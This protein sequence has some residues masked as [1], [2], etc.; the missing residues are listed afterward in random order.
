MTLLKKTI[1]ILLL[2]NFLCACTGVASLDW[3]NDIIGGTDQNFTNQVRIQH[4]TKA[5]KTSQFVKDLYEEIPAFETAQDPHEMTRVVQ[6]LENNMYTPQDLSKTE[7][8]PNDVPY[9]GTTEFK[10]KRMNE[11]PQKRISTEVAL[12]ISGKASG[13]EALQKFVHNDLDMGDPPM[14]WDNQLKTEPTFNLNHTREWENERDCVLGMDLVS[15]S[16]TKYRVGTINT[17]LEFGHGYK[18]GYNVDNLEGNN[19]DLSF[20]FAVFGSLRGVVRNF[21]YDGN[22]FQ[23]SQYHVTSSPFVAAINFA[24]TLNWRNY[25][26]QFNYNIRSKDY[27]EQNNPT[28]TFGVLSIGT[29]W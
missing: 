15:L 20:Y 14:G 6:T 24:P 4:N 11:S 16:N 21:H 26:V 10:A 12:G 8:I 22:F 29:I 9:S 2:I 13:T 5:D 7:P 27:L 3:S 18:L 17:D 28:Q 1:P 23:Q 19:Q 25:V